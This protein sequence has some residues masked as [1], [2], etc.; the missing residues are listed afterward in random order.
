MAR[1]VTCGTCK[2]TGPAQP[3]AAAATALGK[4][5]DTMQHGG[6]PTATTT[7]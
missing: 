2:L 5:H 1:K 7:R 3:T 6:H 4:I